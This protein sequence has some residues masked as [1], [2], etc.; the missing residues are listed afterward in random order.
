M[1][2]RDRNIAALPAFRNETSI[3]REPA[4]PALTSLGQVVY[5][6]RTKDGLV[7]VGFTVDLARRARQVGYGMKSILGWRQGTR[8]D[9]VAA[10]ALLRSAL[11]RG[12]ETYTPTPAVLAFVNGMRSDLGVRP[13]D[14]I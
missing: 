8:E 14:T 3:S 2:K 9:E 7:K 6:V 5:A 11:A 4:S 1:H 10:H 13:I 12:K